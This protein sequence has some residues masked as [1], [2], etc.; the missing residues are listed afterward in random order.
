MKFEK[1]INQICMC[2][3]IFRCNPLSQVFNLESESSL[4]SLSLESESSLKSFN[5]SLKNPI[6]NPHV[7]KSYPIYEAVL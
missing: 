6:Q 5:G 2:G 1:E 7:L 4:K 3:K